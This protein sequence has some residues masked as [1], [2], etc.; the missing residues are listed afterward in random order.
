MF[1]CHKL[2]GMYL[3]LAMMSGCLMFVGRGFL[4]FAGA[5][6]LAHS[7]LPFWDGTCD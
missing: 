6:V 2:S 1:G 7:S 5:G 4:G 3:L